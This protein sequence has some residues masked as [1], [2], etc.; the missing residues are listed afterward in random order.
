MVQPRKGH[1]QSESTQSHHT[2]IYISAQECLRRKAAKQRLRRKPKKANQKVNQA[3]PQQQEAAAAPADNPSP[4][5]ALN[6]AASAPGTTP[7]GD[8]EEGSIQDQGMPLTKV[9]PYL[10]SQLSLFGVDQ[11]WF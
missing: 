3:K 2:S 4:S 10:V 8:E 7:V 6:D 11:A 9:R 1:I 5:P